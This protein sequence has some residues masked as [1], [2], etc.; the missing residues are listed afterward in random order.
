[1]LYNSGQ[2][3]LYR[4]P[5]CLESSSVKIDH[6]KATPQESAATAALR[7]MS[8]RW[9]ARP[10]R[11]LLWFLPEVCSLLRCHVRIT[12]PAGMVDGTE[13]ARGLGRITRSNRWNRNDHYIPSAKGNRETSHSNKQKR[14][15]FISILITMIQYV[16]R[17][18]EAFNV[19]TCETLRDI[20]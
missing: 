13:V 17:I 3:S 4:L 1:M 10:S 6:Q 9:P 11:G 16:H 5:D 12:S 2:P 15:G 20:V 14:A 8:Y 18:C 19:A 7:D